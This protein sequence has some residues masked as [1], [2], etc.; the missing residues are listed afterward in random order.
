MRSNLCDD[1]A[2][3]GR[4]GQ[5]ARASS[6]AVA[7]VASLADLQSILALENK[8]FETDRMSRRS[9]RRFLV[10]PNAVVLVAEEGSRLRG[11]AVV[12]VRRTSDVARLYSIAVDPDCAGRGVGQTLL[13]AAEEAAIARN[14][15]Y[16]RLEVHERNPRAIALYRK[17]DYRQ[18]GQHYEYYQDRGHALRFEKRLTPSVASLADAPPYFYQTTEFTCGP[19][20]LLMALAWADRTFDP[21]PAMEL[22]L[23]R[24]ATTIF[25]STGVGGCEPFGMAVALKR[26]GLSSEIFVSR[27]GPYF[28]D[29]V[30]SAEKRRVMRIAQDDFVEQAKALRLP[31]HLTRADESVVMPALDKGAAAIVLVAGYHMT[32]RRQPHWVFVFGREGRFVLVHDPAASR[33]DDGHAIAPETYAVPWPAFMRMTRCGRDHLEATILVRK[34]FPS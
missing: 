8:V 24:E 28:L 29:T 9:M 4:G 32:P 14:C 18:F 26:H 19:A 6:A 20:C 30:Q 34:G 13:A 16:L 27:P 15:Q 2:S 21:S 5:P 10:S 25:V 12:L 31:V 11:A 23:W 7:R 22:R 1:P 17:A 33:D 3:D